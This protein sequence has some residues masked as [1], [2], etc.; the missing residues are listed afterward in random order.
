MAVH[1]HL[2]EGT[3]SRFVEII[4]TLKAAVS[5]SWLS[6]SRMAP[7]PSATPP[8]SYSDKC[9][10]W[11]ASSKFC[12]RWG[13]P[14]ALCSCASPCTPSAFRSR[15]KRF[16]SRR[17]RLPRHCTH[18]CPSIEGCSPIR[19]WHYL[20]SADPRRSDFQGKSF[21]GSRVRSDYLQARPLARLG[22]PESA[23]PAWTEQHTCSS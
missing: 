3:H 18:S 13:Q 8:I 12:G 14:S 9:N 2:G 7:H 1:R 10:R 4:A 21:D 6:T 17:T 11:P 20:S 5:S 23:L 15:W 22:R 19:S 16:C